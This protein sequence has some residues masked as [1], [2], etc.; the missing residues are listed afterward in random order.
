MIAFICLFFPSL[1]S[2]A[3]IERF[4]KKTLSKR[5]GIYLFVTNTMF[6]N[7][8]CFF[9]KTYFLGTGSNPLYDVDMTPGIAVKYL[10]MAVPI[11]LVITA[12]TACLSK[13]ITID[14]EDSKNEEK[15]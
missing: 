1:F 2:V 13:N 4:T 10:I 15:K 14:V 5:T 8:C 7:F 11:A 6:I 3:L 9:I 12:V